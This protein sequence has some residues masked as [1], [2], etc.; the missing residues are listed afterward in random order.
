[1]ADQTTR[2]VTTLAAAI[3]GNG[4]LRLQLIYETDTQI[5]GSSLWYEITHEQL[6]LLAAAADV[7]LTRA[8]QNQA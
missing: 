7:I 2:K 5:N 8:S 1:M 4:T 6:R 3:N